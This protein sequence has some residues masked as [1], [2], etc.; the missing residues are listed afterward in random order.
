MVRDGFQT[1]SFSYIDSSF[2]QNLESAKKK[3]SC[4]SKLSVGI[5]RKKGGGEKGNQGKNNSG[6]KKKSIT[7]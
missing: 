3:K 5:K 2:L 7:R 1:I 4:T 6:L